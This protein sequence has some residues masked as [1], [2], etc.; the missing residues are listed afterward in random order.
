MTIQELKSRKLLLF[1]C[2]SGSKAYGTDLP[3]SDTDIKGVFVLPLEDYYGLSNIEQVNS[4]KNDEVYYELRR[5]VELL[6]KNNP[7]ILEML[8]TP[9]DCI[10]YCHP[11][12]EPFLKKSFLSKLCKDSFAGF[13]FAQIK[14][15]RG[16]NKKINIPA[17][18]KRKTPLDFCF[19]AE[20]QGSIPLQ[21][22]LE[23][24]NWRQEDCGLV[25]IQNMR[26]LFGLY[27]SDSGTHTFSGIMRKVHANE[28][29]LRSIPKGLQQVAVMSFNKDAYS[30]HCREYREYQTW[31]ENRNEERYQNT[32]SHGKNYDSKN[33][34]HTIRLLDMAIE[35]LE[36]GTIEVRRPNKD[37]LLAIRKGEFEYADLMQKAEEKLDKIE[38]I[39][40]TS[41]LAEQPDKLELEQLLIVT[42]KS[43][44][45]N[46]F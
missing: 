18:T 31:L 13:A 5:F 4:E 2:I 15:A 30:R 21:K 7:G 41:T 35:I 8:A 43:F 26:D 34:M 11:L 17:V 33:M 3:S 45:Q 27:H 23:Q 46:I 16:L 9:K 25:A 24:R 14:K 19:I 44:Y 32:I 20:N 36:T 37:L 42:R 1:E 10:L 38:E 28:I 6:H 22:W 39:Y 40:K 12:F 29:N